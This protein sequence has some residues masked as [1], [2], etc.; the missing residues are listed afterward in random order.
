MKRIAFITALLLSSVTF[1][2][3]HNDY[4]RAKSHTPVYH[5]GVGWVLPVLV[6]GAIVYQLLNQSVQQPSVVYVQ[7]AP[8]APQPIYIEQP[9]Y[10]RKML[11]DQACQCYRE[12]FVLKTQ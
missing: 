3:T 2:G 5:S 4:Y 12:G 7:P 6:G 11:W 1:A 9:Q 8:Q 10:E